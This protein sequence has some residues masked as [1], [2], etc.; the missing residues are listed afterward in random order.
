VT[1]S[2][3]WVVDVELSW[4]VDV[5]VSW[6]VDVE[7]SFVDLV[8]GGVVVEAPVISE[9]CLAFGLTPLTE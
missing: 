4:V 1:L 5:E 9:R 8:V 7:V 2:S 3:A 6:V